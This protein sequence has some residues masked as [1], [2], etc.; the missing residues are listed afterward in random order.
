M[1]S[2]IDRF[3]GTGSN[4]LD[5]KVFALLDG[6][7]RY[8]LYATTRLSGDPV[9]DLDTC[10]GLGARQKVENPSNYLYYVASECSAP[11]RYELDSEEKRLIVVI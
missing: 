2:S 7:L 4:L 3:L 1:D 9:T 11:I 6:I 10:V 8:Y 5:F